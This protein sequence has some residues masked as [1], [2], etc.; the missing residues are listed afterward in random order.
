[1]LPTEAWKPTADCLATPKRLN[2]SASSN[3][4]QARGQRSMALR[5]PSTPSKAKVRCSIAAVP[6][7]APRG[8]SLGASSR[9]QRAKRRASS[10]SPRKRASSA[11]KSRH[12]AASSGARSWTAAPAPGRRAWGVALHQAASLRSPSSR[13]FTSSAMVCKRWSFN[14]DTSTRSKS[15]QHAPV[16][17]GPYSLAFWNASSSSGGQFHFRSLAYLAMR[18][19]AASEAA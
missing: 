9:P 16:A 10:L 15:A 4:R 1:M 13:S 11:R 14:I 6:F 7:E 8:P 12:R 18:S 19:K 17:A 2:F 5:W 3:A